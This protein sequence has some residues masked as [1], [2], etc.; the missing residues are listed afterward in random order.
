VSL[1]LPVFR[2]GVDKPVPFS[3]EIAVRNTDKIISVN[4]DERNIVSFPDKAARN[5]YAS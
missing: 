4:N 3:A 2:K 1:L 5:F